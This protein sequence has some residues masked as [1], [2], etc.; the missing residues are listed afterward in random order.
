MVFF[1]LALSSFFFYRRQTPAVLLAS[2]GEGKPEVSCGIKISSSAVDQILH[3]L[4][5]DIVTRLQINDD[6]LPSPYV[7]GTL[8][9]HSNAF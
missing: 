3:K 8:I 4:R 6:F 2:A 1:F 9:F 7:Q 5:L